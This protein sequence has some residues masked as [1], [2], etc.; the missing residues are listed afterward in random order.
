M[1]HVVSGVIIY[2]LIQFPCSIRERCKRFYGEQC[3]FFLTF[4]SLL[5]AQSLPIEHWTTSTLGQILP[6]GDLLYSEVQ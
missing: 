4:S 5:C 1:Q 3:L 2:A 6:E